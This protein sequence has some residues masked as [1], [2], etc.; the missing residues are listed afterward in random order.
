MSQFSIQ[1]ISLI[2]VGLVNLILGFLIYSKERKNRS[3]VLFSMIALSVAIW[4]LSRALFEIIPIGVW[5]SIITYILYVSASLI[6]LFFVLFAYTFPS[7]KIGLSKKQ[8]SLVFIPCAVVML[9]TLTPGVVIKNIFQSPDI[10]KIIVF[11]WGYVYYGFYIIGYFLWG[12]INLLIK[13]RKERGLL[14]IQLRYILLGT[15]IATFFGVLTNL[16]FPAFN[17]FKLFWLGPVLSV[18]MTVFIAYAIAKHHLLNIKLIATEIFS[19]S[20]ILVVLAELFLLS[21]WPFLCAVVGLAQQ[22][23]RLIYTSKYLPP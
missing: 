22:A 12:F 21:L 23:P 20:I 6:P 5:N 3:N 1:S 7:E 19:A 9:A 16:I 17:S 2:L 8:L 15:F 13:Y 11:G 10:Y 4:V 18:V 14:K